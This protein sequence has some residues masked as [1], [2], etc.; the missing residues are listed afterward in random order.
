MNLL[1]RKV[2]SNP[3][4]EI[5]ISINDKSVTCEE[6]E[7]DFVIDDFSQNR[8]LNGIDKIDISLEYSDMI[9]DFKYNRSSW[10]P[11]LTD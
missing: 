10:L 1:F 2:T 4:T 9:E 7:F 11:K 6:L 5:K 3:N 8:I